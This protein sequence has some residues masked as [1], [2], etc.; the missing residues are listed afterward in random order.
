M[1]TYEGASPGLILER[2]RRPRDG[3]RPKS[4]SVSRGFGVYN[5]YRE[6]LID[7]VALEATITF[8]ALS[9]N[10]RKRV[11]YATDMI[12]A[13]ARYNYFDPSKAK[14]IID[15][16]AGDGV[17]TL[18]LLQL[19]K[20]NGGTVRALEQFPAEAIKRGF[21]TPDQL[22]PGDGLRFFKDMADRNETCDLVTAIMLGPDDSGQLAEALLKPVSRVLHPEGHLIVHSHPRTNEAVERVFNEADIAY[23][24]V[25]SETFITSFARR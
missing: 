13:C 9:N 20:Q 4:E 24:S 14:R 5:H 25:F 6:G 19:A 23:Q 21:L 15:F 2:L 22:H 11:R 17:P 12:N 16:G 1:T 8:S 3:H 7:K 10:D 18:A